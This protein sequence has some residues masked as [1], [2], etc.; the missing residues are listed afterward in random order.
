MII[1][2]TLL[3]ARR[4]FMSSSSSA[5]STPS[6][7]NINIVFMRADHIKEIPFGNPA[8]TLVLTDKD[9]TISIP[10]YGLR[11]GREAYETMKRL[12][13]EAWGYYIVTAKECVGDDKKFYTTV[14]ELK[15]MSVEGA[16]PVDLREMFCPSLVGLEE[17]DKPKLVPEKFTLFNSE[18]KTEETMRDVGL[19][20]DNIVMNGLEKIAGAVVLAK[21]SEKTEKIEQ[22]VLIDD[23]VANPVNAPTDILRYLNKQNLGNKLADNVTITCVWLDLKCELDAGHCTGLGAGTGGSE[24]SHK[25]Q[26]E[27][28]K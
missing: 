4:I 10:N 23:F 27:P 13:Q 20:Y 6:Q 28:Y 26:F 1:E 24:D 18:T 25:K 8:H 3:Y 12:S 11:G 7:P 2:L 5:P 9:L 14:N 19:V 15:H 21:Q 17:K 22:I 16:S